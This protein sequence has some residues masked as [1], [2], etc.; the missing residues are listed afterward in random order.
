MDDVEELGKKMNQ[1]ANFVDLPDSIPNSNGESNLTTMPKEESQNAGQDRQLF[2]FQHETLSNYSI[3]FTSSY[4]LH[5][6]Y[7]YPKFLSYSR[8]T[9]MSLLEDDTTPGKFGN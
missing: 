7:Q 4:L 6:K 5:K 9:S 2:Y 8:I 1:P 3:D